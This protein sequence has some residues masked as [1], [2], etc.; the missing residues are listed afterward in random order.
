MQI[1]SSSQKPLLVAEGQEEE[2]FWKSL[3]GKKSYQHFDHQK[4]SLIC[5]SITRGS[6]GY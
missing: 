4:V 6:T 5:S 3:G 2:D 1:L